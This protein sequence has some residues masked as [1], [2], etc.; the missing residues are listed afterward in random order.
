LIR[1]QGPGAF[2]SVIEAAMPLIDF[3]WLHHTAGKKFDTPESR[4]GLDHAL[5]EVAAR[6]V[7]RSVQHFYRDAFR[8]RMREMGRAGFAKGSKRPAPPLQRPDQLLRKPAFSGER[9]H[10]MILLACLIN[11][12]GLFGWVEDE[13]SRLDMT[14]PAL[15]ALRQGVLMALSEDP[16]LDSRGLQAYLKASGHEETLEIVLSDAVYTHAGFAKP[17]SKLEI[18][19]KGWQDTLSFMTRKAVWKELKEAGRALAADFSDENEQR[20]LALHRS[21]RAG[22]TQD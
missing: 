3:I 9:M 5:E 18:V 21:D 10:G 13:M 8:M 15:S 17:D 7:D 1:A 19:Q 20:I 11:H 22:Q 14:D 2:A 4:A 16:D 12:P 6:I